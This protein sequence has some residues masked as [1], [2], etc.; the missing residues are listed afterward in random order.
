MEKSPCF[1]CERR[2]FDCHIG[3]REYDDWKNGKQAEADEK[4]KK[5]AG[6]PE[7][8]RRVVVQIWKGRLGRR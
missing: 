6:T 8:P 2:R 1:Q 3:C 4:E 5:R 7:L